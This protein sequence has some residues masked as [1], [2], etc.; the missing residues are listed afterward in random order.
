MFWTR[1]LCRGPGIWGIWQGSLGSPRQPSVVDAGGASRAVLSGRSEQEPGPL[2]PGGGRG[3]PGTAGSG[4]HRTTASWHAT[5]RVRHASCGYRLPARLPQ[6]ARGPVQSAYGGGLITGCEPAPLQQL[7][8]RDASG[9]GGNCLPS[10]SDD[11]DTGL[12]ATRVSLVTDGPP[13]RGV[14]DHPR[15][16]PD[17]PTSV[18]DHPTSVLDHPGHGEGWCRAVPDR[19]LK[20]AERRLARAG[21][22]DGTA[23]VTDLPA[24][25]RAR[26]RCGWP[27]TRRDR[28][29]RRPQ[30]QVPPT[31]VSC[32]VRLG[33]QPR[34]SLYLPA[35]SGAGRPWEARTRGGCDTYGM[36]TS[37]ST[38]VIRQWARE[39]GLPVAIRGRLK[40]E[41]VAAYNS[42]LPSDDKAADLAGGVGFD[43]LRVAES[44][45]A[46]R[47][48][49]RPTVAHAGSSRRVHARSS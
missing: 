16:V 12:A 40:P 7:V 9:R 2:A 22:V 18:P 17:H 45:Q 46:L 4:G 1:R 36:P 32:R 25:K 6:A 47:V 21:P 37:A 23:V 10:P 43:E 26:G 42:R 3:A 24:Q 34:T 44:R 30:Q 5:E 13:S 14:R 8:I 11:V 28:Q 49:P 31:S 39:R 38:S 48:L 41:I 33:D 20:G 19:R 35:S 29:L 15:S 27:P